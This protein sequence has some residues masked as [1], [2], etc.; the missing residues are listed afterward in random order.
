MSQLQMLWFEMIQ[1]NNLLIQFVRSEDP[2]K[3]LSSVSVFLS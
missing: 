1:T 2:Q 3:L